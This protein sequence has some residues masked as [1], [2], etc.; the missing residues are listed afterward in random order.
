MK[1]CTDCKHSDGG[2]FARCL[3]PQNMTTSPVD[4]SQQAKI[5]ALCESHRTGICV[6]WLGCRVSGFCGAEGRWFQPKDK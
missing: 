4:G 3:A 6:D 5:L 1:L 2:H